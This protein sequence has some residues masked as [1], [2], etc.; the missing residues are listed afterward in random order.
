MNIFDEEGLIDSDVHDIL[1]EL[2]N[3]GL[4][5]ASVTMGRVMGVRMSIGVPKIVHA[6][7]VI[8][9]GLDAYKDKVGIVMEFQ[10]TI[11]GYMVILIKKNFAHMVL[12]KLMEK[13]CN[14]DEEDKKSAFEEFGNLVCA[15]YL[16][17]IGQYTGLRFY[18]KP[19]AFHNDISKLTT[20]CDSECW[21]KVSEKVVCVDAR[22][23]I[24]QEDKTVIEDVGNVI[25][26]PYEESVETLIE[27]LL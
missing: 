18:V 13:C 7:E 1:Y 27:P 12:E 21:G 25:M 16:K 6:N 5:M 26:L 17:A 19:V 4:G 10:K 22:F 20:E 24:Q 23:N 15:A 8:P 14:F 3:V 2:G 11:K 9:D